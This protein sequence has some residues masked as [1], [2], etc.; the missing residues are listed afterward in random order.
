MTGISAPRMKPGN[1]GLAV[2]DAIVAVTEA[3]LQIDPTK[4]NLMDTHAFEELAQK[5][6]PK[7]LNIYT[8]QE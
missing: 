1:T 3:T 6:P 7:Q 5:N 8:S 4:F 2:Q